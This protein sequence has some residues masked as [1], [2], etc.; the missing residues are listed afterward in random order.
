M[1]LINIFDSGQQPLG[2]IIR[3]KRALLLTYLSALLELILLP[4]PFRPIWDWCGL[5]KDE[6]NAVQLKPFRR[7]VPDCPQMLS[8]HFLPPAMFNKSTASP[9]SRPPIATSSTA[10]RKSR[11]TC[12]NPDMPSGGEGDMPAMV[13]S[14]FTVTGRTHSQ[15]VTAVDI[16][17]RATTFNLMLP[18]RETDIF[19]EL[20]G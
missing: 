14:T 6:V 12:S 18:G 8:L 11:K 1:E 20:M 13:R 17:R 4:A 2:S 10:S 5:E 19:A 7:R 9:A 16:P 3:S 15:S